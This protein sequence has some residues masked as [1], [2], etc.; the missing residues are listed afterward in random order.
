MN[1]LAVTETPEYL[2]IGHVTRD[3]TPSGAVPG[4]TVTY[5]AL[6]ARALGLRVGI[7]TSAG[8]DLGVSPL[9]TIP[10]VCLSAEK[11][12][13]FENRYTPEGREQ[14]LHS[15]AAPVV[16]A[17]IPPEWR[18]SP[19]VH[20]GPV[21]GEVDPGLASLFEGSFVGVTPQGWFRQRQPDGRVLRKP[22]LQGLHPLAQ[23]SAVVVSLEDVSG[24]ESL[25]HEMAEMCPV[26]AVTL[27][28]D[29]CR[30]YWNGDVRRF[31]APKVDEVDPTGAGDI[32]AASFFIRM[33]QTRDP[34]EAARFACQIAATS[35]TRPGLLGVPT[36][37]EVRAAT[38]VVI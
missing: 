15:L 6:T 16:Q 14:W 33:V 30:L 28:R 12:T 34:W 32:F 13:T 4:G 2:A 8:N 31:A 20:L 3:L 10:A 17:A 22:S 29:G 9:D 7:V 27:G 25:I 18:Q 37:A 5:A 23:A 11:T 35:V 24:V 19:I 38:M 26:V 21:A 1:S 36:P